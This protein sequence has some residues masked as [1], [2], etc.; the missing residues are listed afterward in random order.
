MRVVLVNLAAVRPDR[1]ELEFFAI[2]AV[3]DA[4]NLVLQVRCKGWN[5]FEML[6][7]ALAEV[8]HSE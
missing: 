3:P 7:E 6:L 2:N 1:L 5:D 4:I 8:E